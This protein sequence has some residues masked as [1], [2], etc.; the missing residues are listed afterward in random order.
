[1]RESARIDFRKLPP[2]VL[3]VSSEFMAARTQLVVL[4]TLAIS[5]QLLRANDVDFFENEVR[6]ILVERCYECHSEEAGKRKGGLWL[7]RRE[8]WQIG[9]DS[10]AAAVPGNVDKSLLVHS[11][12]YEDEDLQMPPKSRLS[13]EEIAKLEKWIAMGAPDPRDSALV[14]AVRRAPI[15]YEVARKNWAF[16]PLEKVDEPAVADESWSRK[17]VDRFILTKLESEGLKPV[18]D[19]KPEVLIRRVFYDLTGLPPTPDETAAFA[20]NPTPEAF[21]SVVDDLLSRTAFGEKWGRHWLD[22]ARY[23]DSNGGDRNFTFFH[24]WRYRNY[25]IE[26]F[27]DDRSYYQFVR[28][29][30]AGDLLPAADD[31]LRAQ[32]LLGSTFLS[33][34]P[35]MLTERDK[36]KLRLDTADEQVDTV[37]RAFL[38]LTLG[39]ARCHD[40]KFD[41]ISHEDYYAMAGIFRSTQ[42]VMGTRNGC[43]NVASWVEQ[44]LPLPE[45]QRTE[46]AA[47]VERLE[48]AMKLVV[49]K[50]YMKKAGGKTATDNLPLAG[51]LYDNADAELIGDWRV[52]QLNSVRFG[53]NYLVHDPKGKKGYN[54]EKRAVFRASLP[55]SG[56]Y[57][58]R[59]A[60]S[61]DKSRARK[62][63]IT[64]EA[65]DGIETV[66]VD[67]TK[68]PSVAR[69]FQ[70]IGRFRFEKGG[71][72]NVIVETTD[73]DGFIILDAVQLIAVSEIEREAEALAA[74]KVDGPET[75]FTMNEDELKK[76]LTKLL[77]ELRNEEVAMAPRDSADAG[78][79]NL[80]VRGEVGQLGQI[81]PRRFPLAL[82]KGAAPEI[83]EGSSG[84]LELANWMIGEDVAVLDRVMANRIWGWLFGR[85]IVASVDNFGVLGS[86]PTHPDLLD[87]LAAKFRANG[88]SVKSLIREIVLSRAYQLSSDTPEQ[89]LAA[90][91]ENKLLGRRDRRRLSAEE[92]R[93]SVLFLAG[94]LDPNSGAGTSMKYGEDLDKPMDFGKETLR[95]VYLPVARNNIVAEMAMFDAANP[96]LV[97][98]SRSV[99]TAPTQALF[100]LN[101][102][103]LQVQANEVGK[104]AI[105]AEEAPEAE[106]AWLYRKILNRSPR[107]DEAPRAVGF[108]ADIS[109]GGEAQAQIEAAYGH[110]AHLL[111]ASTEFL[112]LD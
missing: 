94:H 2:Q 100:L 4:T 23:A 96:D 47:K 21:E 60:Y 74:A 22:V 80:R 46:L 87:F 97:S 89:L 83:P 84:R 31:E 32:Q 66:T 25:V 52:S 54:G 108:L 93:D 9:G 18:D 56:T 43:V 45:P 17:P 38:G 70:P 107:A 106:V 28:E 88:G 1:M 104:Q 81:V 19:A 78:D 62:I 102:E 14:A 68:T 55:E 91:P 33:L 44:P 24:A 103:F 30:L 110:L 57:E 11:I 7:D 6:P 86:R 42:V 90:D 20:E 105:A 65:W 34:G 101:S 16:R 59:I 99:T 111:L 13:V 95:T 41:P 27:N 29:Q 15:D 39:C 26:T 10:G 75:L 92:I 50:S 35:K 8:G 12:R 67:Q 3:V 112:F 72:A 58:V 5:Q 53:E 69:L 63:P 85:G 73:A 48:L 40:H 82:Q 76:E 64:I 36:E 77:K 71:R 49:E 37:G 79:M 98:G 61:S 51:V 109:G